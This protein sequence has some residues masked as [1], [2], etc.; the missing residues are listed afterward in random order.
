MNIDKH[1]IDNRDEF[2]HLETVPRDAIWAGM[3]Y[4]IQRRARRKRI[5]RYSIAASIICVLAVPFLININKGSTKEDGLVNNPT[6][7]AQEKQYYQL[8]A[9]KKDG[10]GYS[11]LDP[12]IYGDIFTELD[13]LDSMY[14]DLRAEIANTP[15]AARAI[16]TAIRFHERRLHIL[17]LLEKEIE[18]QKR[19]ERHENT[20]KI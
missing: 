10:M 19:L 5:I 16:E 14:I 3:Q 6:L 9:E 7:L 17:E 8:A 15:D 18:N 13:I 20:V 1:I 11:K 4:K 2:D 12:N